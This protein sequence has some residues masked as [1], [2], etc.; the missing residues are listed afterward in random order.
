M[1]RS[2]LLLILT[3]LA[4]LALAAGCSSDPA[5]DERGVVPAE[6][7]PPGCDPAMSGYPGCDEVPY[8]DQYDYYP[9]YGGVYY[10]GTGVV[11]VPE[12]VPVPVPVPTRRP[13]PRRPPPPHRPHVREPPPRV[14]HPVPGNPCP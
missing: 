7:L 11:I 12:P 13:R 9:D 5:Y 10:P 3:C 1:R 8:Y 14:C 6:P 4:A 2:A